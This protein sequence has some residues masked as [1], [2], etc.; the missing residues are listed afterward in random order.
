MAR[1]MGSGSVSE[2]NTPWDIGI[3]A[4][5]FGEHYGYGGG[6]SEVMGS[7]NL[8]GGCVLPSV[9]DGNILVGI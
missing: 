6:H 2:M 8:N 7:F 3:P 5:E 4:H 9:M 1:T